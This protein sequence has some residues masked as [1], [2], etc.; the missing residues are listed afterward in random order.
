MIHLAVLVM[1]QCFIK[2]IETQEYF[3]F[4]LHTHTYPV[5]VTKTVRKYESDHLFYKIKYIER[6]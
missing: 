2:G 3:L 6:H 1:T 4:Y 5:R